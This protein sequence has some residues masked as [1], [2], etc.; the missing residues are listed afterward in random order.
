MFVHYK[1][2]VNRHIMTDPYLVSGEYVEY[3]K[4]N[5]TNHAE[6]KFKATYVHGVCGGPLMCESVVC[7]S[8]THPSSNPPTMRFTPLE[9]IDHLTPMSR[10][11][12]DTR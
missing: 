3:K 9:N 4:I 1:D 2:I 10:N 12:N 8:T 6:Y 11:S 5:V 7:S